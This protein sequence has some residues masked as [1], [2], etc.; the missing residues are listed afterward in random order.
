MVAPPTCPFD[1]CLP[2]RGDTS[3]FARYFSSVIFLYFCMSF[4]LFFRHSVR[5]FNAFYFIVL[6]S[7]HNC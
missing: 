3:L 5:G 6:V 2:V 4:S 1:F 7:Y